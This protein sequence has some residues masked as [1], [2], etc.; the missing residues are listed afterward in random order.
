[1]EIVS[2]ERGVPAGERGVGG[3]GGQK[4]GGLARDRGEKFSLSVRELNQIFAVFGGGWARR[5]NK[6]FYGQNQGKC[7]GKTKRKALVKSR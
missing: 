3:R 1:M 5:K 4:S 7:R 2:R 6:V